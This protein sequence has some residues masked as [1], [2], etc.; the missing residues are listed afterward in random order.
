MRRGSFDGWLS[1][2]QPEGWSRSK[3]VVV[4]MGE[5]GPLLRRITGELLA[6][7]VIVPMLMATLLGAI[8]VAAIL[9]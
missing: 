1:C 3:D 9:P 8:W 6:S 7:G 2:S 4:Y 5:E